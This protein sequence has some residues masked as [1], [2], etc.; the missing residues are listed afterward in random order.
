MLYVIKPL[1]RNVYGQMSP[2]SLQ[3]EAHIPKASL[4]LVFG[5]SEVELQPPAAWG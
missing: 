5:S 4:F 3:W 2:Y 1:M